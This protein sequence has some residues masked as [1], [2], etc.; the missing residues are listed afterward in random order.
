MFTI[1]FHRCLLMGLGAM[2]V[3]SSVQAQAPASAERPAPSVGDVWKYRTIDLWN[4]SELS[5][6]RAELTEIQPERLLFQF[7]LSTAP[8]ATILKST[9]D[10]QSCRAM[11]NSDVEVCAGALRFPLRVGDKQQYDKLPWFNGE[12]YFSQ[13]CEV[14]AFE[15]IK[16]AAGTF[17]AFRIE[18]AGA[19]TRVIG[20]PFTSRA[21]ET[22]WYAPKAH[23]IVLSNYTDYRSNGSLNNRRKTELVEYLPK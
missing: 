1:A 17:D 12:G 18:C 15:P 2:F 4:N 3:I 19:T 11:K 21:D 8:E 5:T 10:L 22:F 20:N 13:S 14:K 6:S 9:R 7:T 16:V 23:R